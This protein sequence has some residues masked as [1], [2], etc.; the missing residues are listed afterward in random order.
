MQFITNLRIHYLLHIRKLSDL[1]FHLQLYMDVRQLEIS[2]LIE[3]QNACILSHG[4]DSDSYRDLTSRI[5]TLSVDILQ[6]NT[7]LDL[8]VE[9]L[10]D[11]AN[12]L[13]T[14]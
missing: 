7:E 2:C 4:V 12:M 11:I 1:L 6:R 10:G 8:F 14:Y 13:L 9:H 5:N 3:A